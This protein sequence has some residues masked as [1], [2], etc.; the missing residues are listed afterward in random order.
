MPGRAV[1]SSG[2][3]EPKLLEPLLAKQAKANLVT[4][5][6]GVRGGSPLQI[7]AKPIDTRM[8]L[9]KRAGVSHD[10]IAKGKVVAAKARRVG[11]GVT[12]S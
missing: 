1:R 6:P 2:S 5:K 11:V 4:A 12:E 7:S 9:A 8:E 10:T 3:R